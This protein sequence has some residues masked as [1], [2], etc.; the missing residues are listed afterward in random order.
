MR[1]RFKWR[2]PG[3]TGGRDTTTDRAR[4]HRWSWTR[5]GEG[6]SLYRLP[7]PVPGVWTAT[8]RASGPHPAKYPPGGRQRNLTP[9]LLRRPAVEDFDLILEPADAAGFRR[10]VTT[11]CRF[12]LSSFGVT[13]N[14]RLGLP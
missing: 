3:G 9:A 8:G 10:A 7:L 14:R 2:Y 1:A 6:P 4:I 5:E 11:N 13:S 12:G